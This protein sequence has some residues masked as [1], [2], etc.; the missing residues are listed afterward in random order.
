MRIAPHDEGRAH[1]ALGLSE[2]L[3]APR[4][5]AHR[6]DAR[7]ERKHRTRKDEVGPEPL[8]LLR[9]LGGREGRR[10]DAVAAQPLLEGGDG[11]VDGKGVVRIDERVGPGHRHHGAGVVGGRRQGRVRKPV[12]SRSGRSRHDCADRAR[13][14]GPE[15]RRKKTRSRKTLDVERIHDASERRKNPRVYTYPHAGVGDFKKL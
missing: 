6:G 12:R 4:G 9:T 5:D 7:V 10:P 11:L 14:H 1:G 13:K 15:Q 8:E 2:P 3:E